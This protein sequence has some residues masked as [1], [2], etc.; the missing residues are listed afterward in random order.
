MQGRDS[1]V[2]K[3]SKNR[4]IHGL[5]LP[6]LQGT[7]RLQVVNLTH[8]QTIHCPK[9]GVDVREPNPA[10]TECQR[11]SDKLQLCKANAKHS[12]RQQQEH[13]GGSMQTSRLLVVAHPIFVEE[14]GARGQLTTSQACW[15]A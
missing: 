9:D 12:Q 14:Q 15:A 6:S 10:S 13:Q 4:L 11:L 2:A 7:Q 1:L 3:E 8:N 5:L